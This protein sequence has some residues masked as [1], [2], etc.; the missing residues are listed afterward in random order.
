MGS[1]LTQHSSRDVLQA[2]LKGLSRHN[3]DKP[4]VKPKA[5][6]SKGVDHG[7]PTTALRLVFRS[8]ILEGIRMYFD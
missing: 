5:C 1:K 2:Q 4:G 7:H 3:R 6:I 8:R